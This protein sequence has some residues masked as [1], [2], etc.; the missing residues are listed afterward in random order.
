MY[1]VFTVPGRHVGPRTA[2]LHKYV[3][4]VVDAP[5]SIWIWAH[6]LTL[7]V[8]T[9]SPGDRH[10]LHFARATATVQIIFFLPFWNPL[11]SLRSSVS[12]C[13]ARLILHAALRYLLQPHT[14]SLGWIRQEWTCRLHPYY[15]DNTRSCTVRSTLSK[16]LPSVRTEAKHYN[17]EVAY[18]NSAHN[19]VPPRLLCSGSHTERPPCRVNRKRYD[20][21]DA[22]YDG[23]DGAP[24][25]KIAVFFS[26]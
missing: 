9:V 26:C 5:A 12:T 18:G 21:W 19:F 23:W 8:S 10:P 1:I 16:Y 25:P 17:T 3:H 24:Q 2:Y 7:G 4:R 6:V 14:R 11:N 20:G 22:C 13:A 15:K